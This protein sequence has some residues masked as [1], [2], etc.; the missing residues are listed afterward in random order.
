MRKILLC[1]PNIS[2]GRDLTLVEKVADEVRGVAAETSGAER[3]GGVK[4]ID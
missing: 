1:E 4:L 2:E 3:N